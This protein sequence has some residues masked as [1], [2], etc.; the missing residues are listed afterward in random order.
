MLNVLVQALGIGPTVPPTAPPVG[1]GNT[2]TAPAPPVAP[3]PDVGTDVLI[4]EYYR[5]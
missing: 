2:T 5:L 1:S 4:S 3:A